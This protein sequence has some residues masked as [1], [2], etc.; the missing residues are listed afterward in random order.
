MGILH[1]IL[2]VICCSTCIILVS[3]KE[4]ARQNDELSGELL[5]EK[6]EGYQGIWYMCNPVNTEY[7]FKYSGGL[8]TYCAKHKPFA[9]Y[10][11]EAKKTYFCYGG[12]VK[13]SYKQEKITKSADADS[14]PGMLLHMVSYYDHKTGQVPKPT[15]L[16]D[17]YT[18]DAHD[19]PVISMDEHGYIWVFSTSHGTG[20]PSFIHKSIKPYSIK[21]FKKINP[22][23][24]VDGK[25]KPFDNFSYL[26]VWNT[27]KT[28][29][30]AFFTKYGF[31]VDRTICYMTSK[32]GIEWSECKRIATIEKGS[33]QVSFSDGNKMATT[34]NIHPDNA[35]KKAHPLN[36]RTNLYYIESTD[37]GKTW[38]TANG[39]SVKL[40]VQSIGHHSLAVEYLSK[41][42]NVYLKDLRFDHQGNP[43]ILFIAS[44]GY[45]PGPESGPRVW[46]IARHV[47]GDWKT[48]SITASDNN[49]DMGSLYIE[50]QTWKIIAPAL[51]GPQKYN[52]GGEVAVWE[53]KDMGRSWKL[54]KNMT[55]NSSFNHTYARRPVNA[56]P[57]F[58][59]FWADGHGREPSPSKLYF[60][61]QQ[62][63]VFLLPEKM[64]NEFEMPKKLKK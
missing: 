13:D 18:K 31:P 56:H 54:V 8:G 55:E 59:A 34:F 3:C 14:I 33:Y 45:E 36:Y 42:K 38:Q 16:L 48:D 9:Y 51:P 63:N 10:S 37:Q 1:K 46:T 40:P 64:K 30:V 58:Y 22:I 5:F 17:K 27:S 62:G 12:T 43:V 6:A 52:P 49:Y 53:S 50:G 32:N 60:S 25:T 19:N 57:G 44:N 47:D 29:F 20:R 7:K 11:K 61:D 39:Q 2:F 24:I 35:D 21:S 28:G 26:Q 23:Y 41:K 15:I 4:Q